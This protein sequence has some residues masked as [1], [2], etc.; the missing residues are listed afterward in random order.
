MRESII[1]GEHQI[2]EEAGQE[3]EIGVE[4]NLR[5]IEIGGLTVPLLNQLVALPR[6]VVRIGRVTEL[7]LALIL[8]VIDSL[9]EYAS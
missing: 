1:T 6:I 5:A 9:I 8:E 7:R 2:P 4:G 3:A